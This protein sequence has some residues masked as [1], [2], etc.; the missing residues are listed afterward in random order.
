M[1]DRE[2]DNMDERREKRERGLLRKKKDERRMR[3]KERGV[4]KEKKR[5]RRW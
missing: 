2:S 4:R 3:Q 5:K 1:E